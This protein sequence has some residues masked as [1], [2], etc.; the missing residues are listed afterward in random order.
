LLRAKR[1]TSRGRNRAHLAKADLRHHPLEAGAR[2]AARGRAAEVIV[3][4]LDLGPAERSKT[5]A[6]RVLQCPALA[7]V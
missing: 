6:H 7:I 4:D 3:D 1:E 2:D 5:L